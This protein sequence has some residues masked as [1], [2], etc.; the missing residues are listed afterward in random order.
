MSEESHRPCP[1]P[2]PMPWA[3]R[4]DLAPGFCRHSPSALGRR[5]FHMCI[6]SCRAAWKCTS[7]LHRHHCVHSSHQLM[8]REWWPQ[9]TLDTCK[10]LD[11]AHVPLVAPATPF[12]IPQGFL[13]WSG[14]ATQR[15]C[16]KPIWNYCLLHPT[17]YS[18]L[19][20]HYN[21]TEFFHNHRTGH[22]GY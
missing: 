20:I 10:S 18:E 17:K 2:A 4:T 13:L 3:W 16:H 12:G 7:K 6:H 21:V 14:P 1:E 5:V 22:P 15:C 11:K 8:A 9:V 19:I